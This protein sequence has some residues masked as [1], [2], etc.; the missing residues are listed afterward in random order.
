MAY[1]TNSD[2]EMRLGGATYVQLTDD[3]GDGIADVAVVDEA[4]L[5]AEAILN[6]YLARRYHVPVDT[7]ALPELAAPLRSVTLDVA[8]YRLR[9]RR[10]P[11]PEPAVRQ[12][13]QAVAWLRSIAEGKAD[14]PASSV[15]PSTVTHSRM[16]TATGDDRLLSREELS[17]Y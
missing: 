7:V 5:A 17:D 6:S 15:P 1:I 16:A 3:D 9:G 13:E 2:I 8:E 14:L 11:L 12:Y 4:R 10:P